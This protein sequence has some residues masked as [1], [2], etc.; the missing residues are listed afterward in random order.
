MFSEYL[1]K[2]LANFQCMAVHKCG[3]SLHGSKAVLD[4]IYQILPNNVWNVINISGHG[5]FS[6]VFDGKFMPRYKKEWKVNYF[7]GIKESY[8][9]ACDIYQFS[10]VYDRNFFACMSKSN[11]NVDPIPREEF[12][13]S[14]IVHVVS[15][16]Q[17]EWKQLWQWMQ[18]IKHCE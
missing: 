4:E 15:F 16:S 18:N 10:I 2:S 12:W 7:I 8:I 3:L 14:A 9:V 1:E 6:H 11:E 5:P 13:V 17:G